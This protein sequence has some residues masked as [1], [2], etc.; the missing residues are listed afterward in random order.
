MWT[1]TASSSY[2][3]QQQVEHSYLSRKKEYNDKKVDNIDKT[4]TGIILLHVLFI[5]SHKQSYWTKGT[6]TSTTHYYIKNNEMLDKLT[7][8]CI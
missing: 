4:L 7:A 6:I 1:Y 2:S 8:D 5:T 3:I